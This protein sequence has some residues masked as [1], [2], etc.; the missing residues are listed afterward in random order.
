VSRFGN[1]M[2]K[3]DFLKS[4]KTL[5]ADTIAQALIEKIVLNRELNLS[6]KDYLIK[7]NI[8]ERFESKASFYRL[9]MVLSELIK[10]ENKNLKFEAVRDKI[11]QFYFKETDEGMNRLALV[12][13]AWEGIAEMLTAVDAKD[14]SL[15]M[16]WAYSWLD[17]IGIEEINPLKLLIFTQLWVQDLIMVAKV[18][19]DLDPLLN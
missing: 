12:Y 3:F 18:L 11:D 1:E 4:K 15:H 2:K 8:A 13:A 6:F 7:D 19:K 16:R 9:A 14:V 5:Y 17:E 10:R